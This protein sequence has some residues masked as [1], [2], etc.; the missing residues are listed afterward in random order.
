MK[1]WGIR[2]GLTVAAG[3]FIYFM[4][5]QSIDVIV[6]TGFSGDMACAGTLKDPCYAYINFTVIDYPGQDDSIFI[7]PVDYD[8]WGRN[9]P[10][11][12]S[13]NI[14]EWKLQ[15]SWG[16]GWRNIPL[17][18]PCT[19]TWCGLSNAQDTRKFSIAFREGRNYSVRVVA[20]KDDSYK[21]VKWG[22]DDVDPYWNGTTENLI[23]IF[24]D[25]EYNQT[26][27]SVVD[28][29]CIK[30]ETETTGVITVN[31]TRYLAFGVKGTVGG[32]TYKYTSM[33]FGWTWHVNETDGDYVFWAENDNENFKWTQ[34]YYFYENP[35]KKM[36]IEHHIKNDLADITDATFYYLANVLPTDTVEYDDTTYFVAN[37][38]V[39]LEGN[40]T[41]LL[42]K[43][44][45]N[46]S[47]DFR[48][49]DLIDNGFTI[50]EF[51]VGNG[52]VIGVPSVNITAVGFTKN[53]GNF[54]KGTEVWVDPT[55]STND[56]ED[57]K[58]VAMSDTLFSLFYGDET[59]NQHLYASYWANGTAK[60][61][62]TFKGDSNAIGYNDISLAALNSTAVAFGWHNHVI[63]KTLFQM[64]DTSGT[65]LVFPTEVDP[66]GT[67]RPG[68]GIGGLNSTHV[69]VCF[70][71]EAADDL[72]CGVWRDS[73]AP[74]ATSVT[75][76]WD[77]DTDVGASA[78]NSIDV[79]T[80]NATHFV[81]VWDDAQASDVLARV[82]EYDGTD[83]SGAISV[84]TSAG[85]PI[86]SVATINSTAFGVTYVD[87]SVNDVLGATYLYDGTAIDSSISFDT[88]VSSS[89]SCTIS[90]MN[91]SALL[92]TWY[93]DTWNSEYMR[94]AIIDG[95][96]SFLTSSTNLEAVGAS[97]VNQE[98]SASAVHHPSQS[99]CND[100]FVH[101]WVNTSSVAQWNAYWPNGTAWGGTCSTAAAGDTCDY[102]S[103]NFTITCSENCT[104]DAAYNLNENWF[105]TTGTG[106][107]KLANNVTNFSGM[108]L[109]SGC[110]LNISAGK[111][112]G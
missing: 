11:N 8:P 98:G 48:L 29:S 46:S 91:S 80:F 64:V 109:S 43:V 90:M 111:R 10:F 23:G 83:V 30:F 6:V 73:G 24:C 40:L 1:T 85:T 105:I 88:D 27:Q 47:Y 44:N 94:Y 101:A 26:E 42:Q 92:V 13:G 3:I 35:G 71:D 12:F 20:Y 108:N 77:V 36:K 7:Y 107:I 69:V 112:F 59:T 66:I 104:V 82:Y 100:T 95:E 21:T 39:H 84:D 86:V 75:T 87:S 49:T 110:M 17:D 63:A 60:Y 106:N 28:T 56:I 18:K 72:M 33:D 31:D 58:A 70:V 57:V 81:V 52:S 67:Q 102:T 62:P 51:Y 99:L 41:S 4:Y 22:F 97:V 96:G 25:L 34:Y 15:R 50:T 38:T 45:F 16:D 14:K 74:V 53:N 89:T 79:A 55:F 32:Q 76:N 61:G 93:D 5:L 78:S 54:P 2:G 65:N 37:Q 103:G 9:T 19:G 68:M